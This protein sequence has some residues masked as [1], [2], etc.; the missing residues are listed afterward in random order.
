MNGSG[1]ANEW[2]W[3]GVVASFN[4]VCFSGGGDSECLII[5]TGG[6]SACADRSHVFFG[7]TCSG[8]VS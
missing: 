1:L 7:P 3:F 8:D 6:G 4:A 2:L 5:L